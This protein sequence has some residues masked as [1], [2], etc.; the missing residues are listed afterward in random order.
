MLATRHFFGVLGAAAVAVSPI[1]SPKSRKQTKHQRLGDIAPGVF[2][3]VL[4][5]HTNSFNLDLAD[6]SI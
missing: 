4:A 3:P 5:K 1:R 6:G 2:N